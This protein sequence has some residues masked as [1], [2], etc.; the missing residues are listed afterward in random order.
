LGPSVEGSFKLT[1]TGQGSFSIRT[2]ELSQV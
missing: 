1:F 2:R